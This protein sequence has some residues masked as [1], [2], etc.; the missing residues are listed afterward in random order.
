MRVL[1]IS[2]HSGCLILSEKEAEVKKHAQDSQGHSAKAQ[3]V[4]KLRTGSW[5]RGEII[6]VL[7]NY[8]GFM[9]AVTKRLL[10]VIRRNLARQTSH[11]L[12][13][14]ETGDS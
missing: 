14:Y 3:S 8:S 10:A 12:T 4:N 9:S 5:K 6:I 1:R 13:H 11:L 7:T 2:E